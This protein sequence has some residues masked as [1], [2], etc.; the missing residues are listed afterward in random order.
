MRVAA[1]LAML[2]MSL[3]RSV[4]SARLGGEPSAASLMW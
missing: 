1:L 2:V 4:A 3:V